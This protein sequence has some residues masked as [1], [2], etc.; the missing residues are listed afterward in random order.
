[1]TGVM[2][3]LLMDSGEVSGLVGDPSDDVRATVATRGECH[4]VLS[5]D[6]SPVVVE[7]VAWATTDPDVVSVLLHSP[8]D[9]VRRVLAIRGLCIPVLSGDDSVLV[10]EAAAVH[11]P[12]LI[13]DPV[14][15]VRVA[16]VCRRN[17]DRAV[18]DPHWSVRL[19][20]AEQG[21]GLDVLVED[22]D[23]EVAAVAR[24]WLA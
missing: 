9:S 16:A 22:P 14:A 10:R 23:P 4:D 12:E 19:A 17:G 24:L 1:M 21:L 11:N 13:G 15:S 7:A 20:A 5:R 2:D 18:S 8:F 6:S 3:V